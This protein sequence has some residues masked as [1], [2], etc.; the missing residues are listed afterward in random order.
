MRSVRV[1]G[2][3]DEPYIQF[4]PDGW[5]ESASI[6]LKDGEDRDFTLL[7]KPLM[8]ETELREGIVEVR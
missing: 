5:V 8:G 1:A 3:P 7:V 2:H 6:H 4:T